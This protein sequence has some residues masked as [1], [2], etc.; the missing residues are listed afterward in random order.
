MPH[1]SKDK[2]R[3]PPTSKWPPQPE[4]HTP[5]WHSMPYWDIVSRSDVAVLNRGAHADRAAV[6]RALQVGA[7]S[8]AF[9]GPMLVW[10]TTGLAH[11]QCF[12]QSEPIQGRMNTSKVSLSLSHSVKHIHTR[13]RA[14]AIYIGCAL[15]SNSCVDNCKHL[16]MTFSFVQGENYTPRD[17]EGKALYGWAGFGWEGEK[18]LSAL[19]F[20][21]PGR[22]HYLD[23]FGL[24]NRRIDH[25]RNAGGKGNRED[26][27]GTDCLHYCLPGPPDEWN[28]NLVDLIQK[29]YSSPP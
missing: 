16:P 12:D 4:H 26:Q 2:D 6:H 24:T 21:A 18:A 10:R 5:G 15:A 19:E 17:P 22:F 7:Q 8:L 13:A 29:H 1:A 20:T 28:Y 11:T 3:F 14:R 27:G 23:A 9:K 25:H